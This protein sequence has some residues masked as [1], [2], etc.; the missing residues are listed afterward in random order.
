MSI[1]NWN[2]AFE[3]LG[4][5][6]VEMKLPMTQNRGAGANWL[7]PAPRLT[8]AEERHL[9]SKEMTVHSMFGRF[10]CPNPRCNSKRWSSTSC[11]TDIKYRFDES[12]QR[13]EIVIVEEF[14]QQC[15]G[16]YL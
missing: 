7:T 12:E 14:G 3:A 11:N 5:E 4:M 1:A 9:Q 15:K 8:I 16:Q 13:G 10:Y 6:L 2:K